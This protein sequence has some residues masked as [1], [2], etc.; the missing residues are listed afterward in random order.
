MG[1]ARIFLAEAGR[2]GGQIRDN[3]SEF[4]KNV[5]EGGGG[6]LSCLDLICIVLKLIKYF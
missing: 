3:S 5:S 6:G 2:G 4:P 1:V